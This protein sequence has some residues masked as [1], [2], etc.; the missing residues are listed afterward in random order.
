MDTEYEIFVTL[1]GDEA[2]RI[3]SVSGWENLQRT[4]GYYAKLSSGDIAA[5]ELQTGEI[6]ARVK[7]AETE[8][9]AKRVRTTAL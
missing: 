1:S 6:I 5:V 9:P 2:V 3:G 7:G 4:L 8:S